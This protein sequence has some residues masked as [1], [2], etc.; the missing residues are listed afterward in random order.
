MCIRDRPRRVARRSL[1]TAGG[2][3]RGAAGGVPNSPLA[4]GSPGGPLRSPRTPRPAGQNATRPPASPSRAGLPPSP[5]PGRQRWPRVSASGDAAR[6]ASPLSATLERPAAAGAPVWVVDNPLSA[7]LALSTSG[8]S[9]RLAPRST[10]ALAVLSP[11]D[12]A[13]L[14][15]AFATKYELLAAHAVA[16]A[17]AHAKALGEHVA[18]LD[19]ALASGAVP[20]REVERSRK[21]R[22]EL[23]LESA[24]LIDGAQYEVLMRA[25]ASPEA[26]TRAYERSNSVVLTR[27]M[28][29]RYNPVPALRVRLS[30]DELERLIAAARQQCAETGVWEVPGVDIWYKSLTVA[31]PK[32]PLPQ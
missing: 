23:Q 31:N 18:A 19:A 29:L 1:A 14:D 25:L 2:E 11:D 6:G 16:Q 7:P 26:L 20:R 3:S 15:S 4:R 10:L 30:A 12:D 22:I 5:N 9:T 28:L 17:R 13:T 32:L 27:E 24:S 21:A 8:A